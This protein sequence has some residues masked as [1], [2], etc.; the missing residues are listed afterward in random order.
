MMTASSAA[1]EGVAAK[2][3]TASAPMAAHRAKRRN[4]R[5]DM[6]SSWGKWLEGSLERKPRFAIVAASS[7]SQDTRRRARCYGQRHTVS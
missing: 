6:V 3:A 7:V 5:G 4:G 1:R 2:A